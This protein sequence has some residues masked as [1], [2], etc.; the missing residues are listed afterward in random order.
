KAQRR[1]MK[2]FE[3]ARDALEK[4]SCTPF[5]LFIIRPNHSAHLGHS[6]KAILHFHEIALRFPWVAPTPIDAQAPLAWRVLARDVVLL[7]GTGCI[8]H[9]GL[10]VPDTFSA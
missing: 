7:V 2:Q 4:L 9:L 6:R 10:S 8:T 1:A 3:C 5:R